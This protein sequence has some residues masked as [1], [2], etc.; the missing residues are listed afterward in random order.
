MIVIQ[1]CSGFAM[2]DL[3]LTYAR[4]IGYA[5]DSYCLLARD[6]KQIERLMAQG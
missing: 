2:M 1:P 5:K 6:E 3:T 4:S